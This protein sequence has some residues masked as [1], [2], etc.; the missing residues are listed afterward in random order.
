MKTHIIHLEHHDNVISITDKLSWGKAQ[1]VLLV[2]P[3]SRVLILQRIDL[4]LIQRAAKNMGFSIGLVSKSKDV[5]RLASELIIP[6]FKSIKDAQ[7]RTWIANGLGKKKNYEWRPP[8]DIRSMGLEAKLKEPD[9]KSHIGIRLSFFSLGVLAVLVISLLFVPSA[10]IHLKLSDQIQ[11]ISMLVAANETVEDVNLLGTIPAHTISV[12]VEGSRLVNINSETKVPD[13]SATGKITFTNL[14]EEPVVIPAGT[15]VTRL[16]NAGIRFETTEKGEV[17]AGIGEKVDLSIRALTPGEVGN[18]EAN[19]LGSLVGD[20]GTSLLAINPAPTYG[21]TDRFTAMATKSDRSDL[22]NS[23]ETEL[24]LKAIQ[25]AQALLPEGDIIFPDTVK[26]EVN[27]QENFVPAVGQPGDRLSLYLMLS[28]TMQYVEYSDLVRLAE[29]ALNDGLP[30]GYIPVV[31]GSINIEI[32]KQPSTNTLGTTNM[33]LQVS[34]EIRKEIDSLYLSRLV[35]GL[36]AIKAY[37]ILEAKFG[38]DTK[39]LIEITPSWW[40]WLPIVALRIAIL[41]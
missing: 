22:F 26:I 15:I 35:Q 24:R 11:S 34:Q 31:D 39:P 40:P 9:W 41:N 1:R 28:Y 4:V 29:P 30:E 37:K 2:Y 23:L 27:L 17:A 21:A 18:M 20:L 16:D 7:H 10:V 38:P 8:K 33:N 12:D 6:V 25:E 32:L 13:K 5:R 19:S 36:T 14:T 3:S